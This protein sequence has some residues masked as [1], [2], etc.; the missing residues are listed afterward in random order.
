MRRW[1]LILLLLIYPFQVSL[2]LADGCCLATAAG[3]THHAADSNQ[4]AQPQDDGYTGAADP[5]CAACTFGHAAALP[6]LIAPMPMPHTHTL[7]PVLP[8]YL[9]ASHL[10]G[11][12]DR[13]QWSPAAL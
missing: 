7:S 5:H 4:S 11:R 12:P 2:A 10:P 13:P 8:S 1:L 3:V 9:P 6:Q